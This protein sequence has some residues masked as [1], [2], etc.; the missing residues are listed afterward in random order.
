MSYFAG[1][2]AQI[3]LPQQATA[4]S[5]GINFPQT[6]LHIL[7]KALGNRSGIFLALSSYLLKPDGILISSGFSRKRIIFLF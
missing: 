7:Q 1:F 5:S 3:R 2:L 4:P 6:V